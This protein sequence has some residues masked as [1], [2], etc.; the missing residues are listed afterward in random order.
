MPNNGVNTIAQLRKLLHIHPWDPVPKEA[1][2]AFETA[3]ELERLA[4]KNKEIVIE[5]WAQRLKE[6]KK[7]PVGK[8]RLSF[9][10]ATLHGRSAEAGGATAELH[11]R[12]GREIPSTPALEGDNGLIALLKWYKDWRQLDVGTTERLDAFLAFKG[13]TRE[14]FVQDLREMAHAFTKQVPYILGYKTSFKVKPYY[15]EKKLMPANGFLPARWVETG[16][17]L[18]LLP[19]LRLYFLK[20]LKDETMSASVIQRIWRGYR[21]RNPPATPAPAAAMPPPPPEKKLWEFKAMTKVVDP[22]L[23]RLTNKKRLS[24]QK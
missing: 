23:A 13:V 22:K 17:L 7:S 9:G 2:E 16:K 12:L 20:V 14:Q 15:A 21:V 3:K 11:D 5:Q 18:F 8:R 10:S 24:P 6:R 1:L 19:R 4:R